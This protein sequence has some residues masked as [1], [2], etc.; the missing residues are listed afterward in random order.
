MAATVLFEI[1]KKSR[2]PATKKSPFPLV[3]HLGTDKSSIVTWHICRGLLQPDGV[4]VT[5]QEDMK[6][7]Y[8]MGYFGKGTL[9][10]S[11][12]RFN[13]DINAEDP[14][15]EKGNELSQVPATQAASGKSRGGRNC[16]SKLQSGLAKDRCPE[17]WLGEEG[18]NA[19]SEKVGDGEGSE[20]RGDKICNIDEGSDREAA[21]EETRNAK[22][23]DED[24]DIFECDS[25]GEQ[26][27]KGGNEGYVQSPS[28]EPQ[29]VDDGSNDIIEVDSQ[30]GAE[31]T[32]EDI[33]STVVEESHHDKGNDEAEKA[34]GTSTSAPE[35]HKNDT[36]GSS[37]EISSHRPTRREGR[38]PTRD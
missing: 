23:G 33:E 21:D 4:E 10:R 36:D 3:F 17:S 13:T 2:S 32:R 31:V 12:P 18:G 24:P 28:L 30:T 5:S 6:I 15:L 9:S 27:S 14:V 35:W 26:I 22:A 38:G 11:A 8:H 37:E 25:S 29:N 19:G 34:Q 1:K 7:L 20:N 16:R